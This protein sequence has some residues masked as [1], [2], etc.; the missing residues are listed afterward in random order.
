MS[1]HGHAG[2]ILFV[3][4]STGKLRTERLDMD[5]AP[6]LMGGWGITQKLAYD[7]IQPKLDPLSTESPI[8]VGTGP[9]T[10]TPVPGASRLMVTFKAPQNGAVITGCGGGHFAIM[11]KSSGY[12]YVVITGRAPRPV[13]LKVQGADSELCDASHLWGQDIFDTVDALR[14]KH[15]PC[16]V[17]PI[18]QAGENLV[19]LSVATIDK[20]GTVGGGGLPAVMGSKNLKALVAVQG[21]HGMAVADWHR[22]R[23]LIDQLLTQIMAYHLREDLKK[24][25]SMAMTAGWR[26]A[27]GRVSGN[28]ARLEPGAPKASEIATQAYEVHKRS[29]RNLACPTCPMSDKDR[30]DLDEGERAG[31]VFYDSAVMHVREFDNEAS[32]GLDAYT[33]SMV[34]ID[35]VNRYGICRRNFPHLVSFMAYL[36][37]EG[38]IT[39]EDTGGIEIKE[40]FATITR[41]VKMT[42]LREGIGDILADGLQ[43]LERLGKGATEY[44]MHIKGGWRLFDP[45]LNTLGTLEFAQLVNPR[46]AIVV[47][48]GVGAPSYNPGRPVEEWV[49]QGRREGMSEESIRRVFGPKTF[50]VGRLTKHAE[51][52]FS[53][54]NC[55]GLCHRLYINRFHDAAPLAGMYSAVTGIET[56]PAELMRAGERAWNLYKLLNVREGFGRKDDRAPDVWF[57]PMKAPDRELPLMDYHKT[58][59]LTRE[60]IEGLI[61]DYYDE[62]GWDRQSG[63]P[64]PET[65]AD[66]GLKDIL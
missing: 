38:I 43:G 13:Y 26:G 42:A 51:D 19:R 32:D 48:G 45:R 50:N 28:W 22:L 33:K 4:L 40:D 16:S 62:R 31:T 56:T 10:G 18:G 6:L 58:H 55:L 66:L 24:G 17:I 54:F 14:T 37:D 44:A 12:D 53:L 21:E 47:P 41:L 61:S 60:E 39:K 46:A 49:R 57:Q 11:L 25:G 20:G 65:L 59:V 15:E 1:I 36:Y 63:I 30:I 2:R 35:L 3:D 7:L 8:I 23:R 5:L 27:G 34:Y 52:W 9:F 29:R 64:K